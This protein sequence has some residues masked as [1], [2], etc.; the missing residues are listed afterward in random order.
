VLKEL[1]Q[2][3]VEHLQKSSPKISAGTEML[4][5]LYYEYGMRYGE[6]NSEVLACEVTAWSSSSASV[7]TADN[8]N[9]RNDE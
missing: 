3:G 5:T 1:G 8:E 2:Q 4:S 9:T 6:P 7:L